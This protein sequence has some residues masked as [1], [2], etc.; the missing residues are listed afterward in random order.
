MN[1]P[2]NN[3]PLKTLTLKKLLVPLILLVA[4]LLYLSS[5]VQNEVNYFKIRQLS[6][7][8]H[9]ELTP[10]A[11]F[12]AE[13]QQ[14]QLIAYYQ[15]PVL[16]FDVFG[17]KANDSMDVSCFYNKTCLVN[18]VVN[19]EEYEQN[20][21]SQLNLTAEELPR[22]WLCF[23][24]FDVLILNNLNL[25]A[26]SVLSFGA[27]LEELVLRMFKI[28]EEIILKI[29]EFIFN[30]NEQLSDQ[31]ALVE[32]IRVQ[33]N[34]TNSD[35]AL[36]F[37]NILAGAFNILV[38][39]YMQQVSSDFLYFYNKLQNVV[40]VVRSDI[41]TNEQSLA[42]ANSSLILANIEIL[43]ANYSV[44]ADE[45][46]QEFDKY[47]PI[48]ENWTQIMEDEIQAQIVEKFNFSNVKIVIIVR[49]FLVAIIQEKRNLMNETH[50]LFNATFQKYKQNLY[51]GA[52]SQTTD[53]NS[54]LDSFKAFIEANSTNA[55]AEFA[56]IFTD[57]AKITDLLAWNHTI[58]ALGSLNIIA[59][60]A[61]YNALIQFQSLF[62]EF[63]S[64]IVLV[65]VKVNETFE[66]NYSSLVVLLNTTITE[67]QAYFQNSSSVLYS[68]VD[69]IKALINS[70]EDKFLNS[71]YELDSEEQ[72]RLEKFNL[73][74]L[75]SEISALYKKFADL[76]EDFE[77]AIA[78]ITLY[79]EENHAA[80]LNFT[81]TNSTIITEYIQ[82]NLTALVN[83]TLIEEI[84]SQLNVENFLYELES[85]LE[86]QTINETTVNISDFV[87]D[88]AN[89]SKNEIQTIFSVFKALIHNNLE[90]LTDINQTLLQAL[91]SKFSNC[92][93]DSY[94]FLETPLEEEKNISANLM[95][96]SN[97]GIEN[98]VDV[99]I[100]Y[101]H[102]INGS[103]G[104][105]VNETVAALYFELVF[106]EVQYSLDI[107]TKLKELNLLQVNTST[108]IDFSGK[109]RNLLSLALVTDNETDLIYEQN[110]IETDLNELTLNIL[111]SQQF[112]KINLNSVCDENMTSTNVTTCGLEEPV[113]REVNCSYPAEN[114]TVVYGSVMN[115]TELLN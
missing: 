100:S 24:T 102:L 17:V 32:E 65:Q 54:L 2:N 105:F 114:K 94:N 101:H 27:N 61:F 90:N 96:Y 10:N 48:E 30:F 39:R 59:D 111:T 8:N 74:K 106:D 77:E 86:I 112:I 43:R 50:D 79:F 20:V 69:G 89:A 47:Q 46:I 107:E 45:F 33:L 44:M 72:S 23:G 64:T 40:N 82:E 84:I 109:L 12:L 98:Q 11:R 57:E 103:Y 95:N 55:T 29:N 75:G 60:D 66:A 113:I 28:R 73:F 41:Q 6:N 21:S 88:F 37:E 110:E 56:S 80:V 13:I 76:K 97:Y 31:S 92:S 68:K 67:L 5:P 93:F 35:L 53:L 36:Q 104:A 14:D 108:E 19:M 70:T 3:K 38:G 71:S 51:D 1:Q 99:E 34:N 16:S 25:L 52:Q 7:R 49:N 58:D 62:I 85:V 83:K 18:R 87:I 78:N 22:A 15:A 91:K 115:L 4:S 26:D 9:R 81:G 42:S 63:V